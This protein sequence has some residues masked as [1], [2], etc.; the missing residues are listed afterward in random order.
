M[1]R[2][3]GYDTVKSKKLG[4]YSENREGQYG[5]Y[6][7]ILYKE[8]AQKHIVDNLEQIIMISNGE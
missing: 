1:T 5:G 7:A 8:S 4:I 3:S 6:L 2:L